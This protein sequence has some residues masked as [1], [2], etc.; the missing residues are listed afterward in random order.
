[1]TATR[2]GV[3]VKIFRNLVPG[4]VVTLGE[5][6]AL[7][8]AEDDLPLGTADRF[9]F[10]VAG[11]E[12]TT[13]VTLARL[14]I[15]TSYLGLLGA[16]AIGH[17]VARELR[18]HGVDLSGVRMV[19]G[20]RTAV[21]IRDTPRDRPISVQYHRG[22]SA[23]SG[24]ACTDVP[25]ETVAG[26]AVLHLTG[27]TAAISETARQAVL[28]AAHT[29]RRAGVTVTFDP[30]VR[31][32]LAPAARWRELIDELARLADVVLVGKDEAAWLFDGDPADWFLERGASRVVVKDGAAGAW[33]TD[34]LRTWL[35]PARIVGAVDPVGAGDAFAGGWIAGW[36][37]G[38]SPGDRLAVATTVASMCVSARG[39]LA[40]LPDLR[41]L[42]LVMDHNAGD[43]CR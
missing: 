9:S 19:A 13:A 31:A 27:I 3:G 14:G 5:V 17:Q 41:T 20:E 25:E 40:G 37:A 2:Q 29:A 32:S 8:L 30:N 18:G 12:A 43:V 23:A 21:L 4:S 7:L 33:E 10:A 24:L 6:M 34:G 35:Q 1:M 36:L 16:D 38:D 39:D 26:A 22:G 15:T 42:A 11:A 28:H